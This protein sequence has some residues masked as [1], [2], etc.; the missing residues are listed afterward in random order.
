MGAALPVISLVASG[1]GTAMSIMGQMSSAKAAAGAANY[2]AAINE[3]NSRRAMQTGEIEAGN[4]S[5]RNRAA[6]GATLAGQASKGIDVNSGSAVDVQTS[7]AE[8]GELNALNVRSKAAQEA[9]NYKSSAVLDRAEAKNDIK[10]GYIGAA[11]TAASGLGKFGTEYG[12]WTK[13]K[14]LD[15]YDDSSF[16]SHFSTGS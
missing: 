9:Y 12:D 11:S 2:N 5:M 3:Q 10:A 6:M 1:L 8:L 14:A 7:Q 16:M 13:S 15:S 4:A